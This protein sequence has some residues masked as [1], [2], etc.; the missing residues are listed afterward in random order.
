MANQKSTTRGTNATG[1]GMGANPVG[2]MAPLG[3]LDNFEVA[4]NIPDPRGWDVLTADGNKIGKVHELIVD[5]GALRTRYIDITLDKKALRLDKEFDVLIPIGDA[6]VDS[7]ADKVVIDKLTATQ[8]AGLP[9]FRHIEIT[10]EYE[11]SVL[12]KFGVSPSMALGEGIDFYTDRHFDDKRFYAPR[13]LVG[14]ATIK[15]TGG[16]GV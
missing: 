6:Q 4:K 1:K 16:L 15:E 7:A 10:R 5:A 3:E 14:D 2:R 9:E 12:P 11:V 8:L 13:T